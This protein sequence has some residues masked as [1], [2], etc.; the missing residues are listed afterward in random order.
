MNSLLCPLVII[1]PQSASGKTGRRWPKVA[2]QLL[3]H[4]PQAEF[5]FTQHSGEATELVRAALSAGPRLI[6]AA[7]GDGTVNEV[8]N[9]FFDQSGMPLE[10]EASLGVLPLGTG[11]DLCRSLGVP[12]DPRQAIELLTCA[13]RQLD[14]GWAEVGNYGRAF[15]NIA[16]LGISSEIAQHFEEHGKNGMMSYVSGLLSAARRYQK[17]GFRLKFDIADVGAQPQ[18]VERQLPSAFVLALANGQFFGGGMH[19]APQAMLDDGLFQCVLVREI[20]T[21]EI[22]RYLPAL[23]KGKHLRHPP[24]DALNAREVEISVTHDTRLELDGEPLL[25][26]SPDQPGRLKILPQSI[27]VHSGTR[28]RALSV[29]SG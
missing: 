9:G 8:V 16:S 15:I 18:W 17:R 4:L 13:P 25:C 20:S 21:L 11:S 14:C 29:S 12:R 7:G 2:P 26:L 28:G 22:L 23:F 3:A 5:V 19:I 1:N 6:I 24:F 10:P 27:R